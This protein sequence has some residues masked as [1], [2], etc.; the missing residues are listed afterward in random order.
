MANNVGFA[1]TASLQ[2]AQTATN[3]GTPV[4]GPAS[5]RTFHASGATSAGAGS[6]TIAI[7]GSM[8]GASWDTLGTIT[9]TLGTTATSDGFTSDDRYALVRADVT[10]ISGTNASVTVTMGY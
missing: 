2:S 4:P 1:Q 8:N 5:A 7:K 10:A 6:A 3:T 9:L